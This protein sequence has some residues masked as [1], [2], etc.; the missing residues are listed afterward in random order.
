VAVNPVTNKAYVT[1]WGVAISGSNPVTVIDG[2]TNGTTTVNVGALPSAVAVNPVTN[3]IYIAN[4]GSNTVTVIDGATNGTTTVNV[5]AFPSA[6]AVNPV[7]NQIY[8]VNPDGNSVTVIDGATNGTITVNV[9]AFPCAVAV[10]P[11][12]NKIYVVNQNSNNV[13]VIDGGSLATTTVAVGTSPQS[14]AVNSVTNKVYVANT[15]GNSVT[16]LD[17]GSLATATMAVGTG[18]GSVAVNSLTNK[19]YVANYVSNAVTVID[20]ATNS[21]TTVPVG[22]SPRAVTVDPVSNKVYVA[23]NGSDNVTVIDG[24]TNS[25]TTINAGAGSVAVAVNPVTNQ[26]YVANYGSANV[27]VITPQA[28]WLAPLMVN[29]TPLPDNFNRLAAPF[30]ILTPLDQYRPNQSIGHQV[31]YQVDTWQ[32]QWLTAAY[33]NNNQWT[34]APTAL[35]NGIHILYAYATDGQDAGSINPSPSYSPVIGSIAAYV[36]LVRAPWSTYADVAGACGGHTPCFTGIQAAISSTIDGGSVTVYPGTYAESVNANQNVAITFT[37][38]TTLTALSQLSGTLTAPMGTL[39][40][41]GDFAHTGGTFNANGGTVAF[42]GSNVTRTLTATVPTQFYNLTIGTGVTLTHSTN[43]DNTGVNGTLTNSGAIYKVFEF[44][45]VSVIAKV[46]GGLKAL[47]MLRVDQN[48]PQATA[49]I[50]TGKFWHIEPITTTSA[51]FDIGLTLPHS[52]LPDPKVCKYPGALGGAGW[53]CARDGFDSLAVWRSGISAL[54]D[55]AVGNLVG[56][57]AVTTNDLTA[58]TQPIGREGPIGV[59]LAAAL[60]LNVSL[61][62][63]RKRQSRA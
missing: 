15:D 29:I 53:D 8:V 7:T 45:G 9:G 57:T 54:S 11:V 52:N 18:P 23:N 55:W 14:V 49:G 38:A 1:N 36:F 56:P 58:A 46:L 5:G 43:N 41:N 20:G 34:A 26:V 32:G 27:T 16:I 63:W 48:H 21:T 62:I 42:I 39:I 33:A 24:A 2:A 31:Y 6:V 40:L 44:S 10:N 28:A 51:A 4:S 13:T 50:Q 47:A 19:I 12:T 30:F 59:V 35:Q 60:I 3:K 22:T 17:G 25:T 61:V 37:G